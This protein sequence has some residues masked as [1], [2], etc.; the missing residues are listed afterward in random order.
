MP[1]VFAIVFFNNE[2]LVEIK[3][4]EIKIVPIKELKAKKA[5]RNKHPKEQIEMLAKHFEY[6]GFRNPII[7]SNQSGEIVCGH[8]RLDAAKK[9]GLKEVPVIYQDFESPEQ[10]YAYH[11]ADNG[12]GLWSEL[13]MSGIN[14][15][16]GDLGPDFDI[17]L[18][19]IKNFT[20]DVAEQELDETTQKLQDD[21]N[22]KYIIEVTFPN[23]MEMMD[24]HDDLVSRGYIVKI[25]DFKNV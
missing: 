1:A 16:I 12:L 10:E 15:D 6:Q 17:D 7:V 4:K 23:D 21:M 3:S 22:K 14:M 18:L 9:A 24:I 25:K 11:V 5:N 2:V 13:D 19:G 8:G 20:I